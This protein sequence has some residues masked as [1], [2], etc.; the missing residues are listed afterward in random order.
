M[1]LQGYSDHVIT[2]P[3]RMRQ[4]TMKPCIKLC[5]A[6]EIGRRLINE[7]LRGDSMGK[8]KCSCA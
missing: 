4:D 3:A 8:T 6:I 7:S 1:F 2:V 5:N